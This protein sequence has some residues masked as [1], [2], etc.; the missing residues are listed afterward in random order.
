MA[1]AAGEWAAGG[2]TEAAEG[3]GT[4]SSSMAAGSMAP[5]TPPALP[6]S[7]AGPPMRGS[8]AKASRPILALRPPV[9]QL[10]LPHLVP[11]GD[12]QTVNIWMTGLTMVP[13]VRE[14]LRRH[15]GPGRFVPSKRAM[16]EGFRDL[17]DEEERD[18]VDQSIMLM[19]DARGPREAKPPPEEML[20]DHVGT[21]PAI[22]QQMLDHDS[23]ILDVGHQLENNWPVMVMNSAQRPIG[24]L[25][26]CRAGK[27]RSVA[28]AYLIQALLLAEGYVVRVSQ[29]AMNVDDTCGQVTCEP[30]TTASFHSIL[31]QAIVKLSQ[32]G[33]PL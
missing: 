6:A 29:K 26:Y 25:L 12:G 22:M 31:V 17:L 11:P 1:W 13:G 10:G 24:I 18:I 33:A 3:Q 8:V 5:K 9:S 21:H 32:V 19:V 28:W 30:C 7:K 14:P 23:F 20:H 4:S 27:H 16:F 15:V 2:W